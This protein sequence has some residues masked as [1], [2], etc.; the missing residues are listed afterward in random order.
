MNYA[1]LYSNL[2]NISI[3]QVLSV[4][5]LIIMR[6]A[7]SLVL[8]PFFGAKLAPG[9][10][11]MGLAICVATI[12]LPFIAV[13]TTGPIGFS[14]TYILYSL[15]EILVGL[16]LGFFITVPFYMVQTAGTIIDYLRGAS[17]MQAQDP[18]MQTQ[19]S[20]IGI[21]FNYILIVIFFQID[22]PFLFFDALMKSYELIPPDKLI[23]PHFLSVKSNF[24]K[25]TFDLVNQIVTIAIQL[26]APA[27]VAILMAEMFLGIANRLAPQVQIAFLGMS[28]KSLLGLGL[29]FAAWYFILKQFTK[30]GYS[31]LELLN[32]LIY[33]MQGL[34]P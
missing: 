33:S 23:N 28:I 1:E 14:N 34:N 20:P 10:A 2:P 19:T 26:A 12:F 27:L 9:I 31:W 18:S 17:I 8:A 29:L 24:W 25:V 6:I 13:K 11:R 30:Q 4:F 22:G 16:L 21:L 5:F 7:P 15:K 3:M 32:K